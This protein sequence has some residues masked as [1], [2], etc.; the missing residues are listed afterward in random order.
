MRIMVVEDDRITRNLLSELLEPFDPDGPKVVER[1]EE[2]WREINDGHWDVVILDVFL[3]DSDECRVLGVT[4]EL[5][6]IFPSL[7]IIVTSGYT[8]DRFQELI[9]EH[10]ADRFLPK[11][12]E[13]SS[14]YEVLLAAV[15]RHQPEDP[16]GNDFYLN[17]LRQYVDAKK[18][19]KLRDLTP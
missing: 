18:E 12:G 19:G 10:G 5:R 11:K 1:L 16:N 13:I 9:L 14:V 7:A 17:V 2:M 15:E 6:R 3:P 4:Q 8:D